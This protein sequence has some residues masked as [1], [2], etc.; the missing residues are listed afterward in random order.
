MNEAT[1]NFGVGS[2]K[3]KAG[4]VTVKLLNGRQ[5]EYPHQE[6]EDL[7]QAAQAASLIR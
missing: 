5:Y 1:L 3:P 7:Y 2:L 6:F 4:F